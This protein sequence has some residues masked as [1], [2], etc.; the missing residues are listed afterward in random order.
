MNW[1]KGFPKE[2]GWHRLVYIFEDFFSKVEY[3]VL[4]AHEIFIDEKGSY[5]IDYEGCSYHFG[6]HELERTWFYG[7]IKPPEFPKEISKYRDS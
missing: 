1:T 2:E 4:D 6:L 7:P 5:Y 3:P